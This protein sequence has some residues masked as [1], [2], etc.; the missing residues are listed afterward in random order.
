M[1]PQ[2]RDHPMIATPRTFWYPRR[3]STRR[4]RRSS[5]RRRRQHH[6]QPNYHPQKYHSITIPI[7][8]KQEHVEMIQRATNERGEL[9]AQ[10]IAWRAF[11][12]GNACERMG[13]ESF[14]REVGLGAGNRTSRFVYVFCG[15]E[16][17]CNSN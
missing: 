3:T 10:P 9:F 17:Y 12:N 13:G 7:R 1:S 15:M 2:R 8:I 4:A 6:R 14:L 5:G 16:R 11:A